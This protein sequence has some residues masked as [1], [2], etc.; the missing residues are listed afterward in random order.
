M[1]LSRRKTFQGLHDMIPDMLKY[2]KIIKNKDMEVH[3]NG[4]TLLLF[5]KNTKI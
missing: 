3:A 2:V 5:C 1:E 4:K